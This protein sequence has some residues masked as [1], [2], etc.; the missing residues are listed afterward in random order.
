V[1]LK[2]V[3]VQPAQ[4]RNLTWLFALLLVLG[5]IFVGGGV[6]LSFFS[7]GRGVGEETKENPASEQPISVAA[8][9]GS[10]ATE[11]MQ[12]LNQPEIEELTPTQ[13]KATTTV[14]LPTT[15]PVPTD[16][17]GPTS[18]KEPTA[19]SQPTIEPSVA[20][21]PISLD[22]NQMDGAE[23]V[24]VPAG[25]FLMGSDADTDPYFYGAEGP[26]HTV[27][28]DEYW[29]YR[30]EVTN[31]MYQKC[32]D[33]QACPRPAK[34]SS[35]TRDDYFTNPDYANYPVVFV[36]WRHAAA[37]CV[38]AGG[39]L[40]YEAEW[41]KAARGTDGRLFPWGNSPPDDQLV[42][43]N[44]NDTIAVGNYPAGASPYGV[45]DM[46]GNVIEWVFDFF[47]P[48]YYSIS[49][50]I[51]PLGPA[52]GSARVFRG[53][54]YHNPADGIRTV[55]RGSRPESHANVDFGFRCV[56]EEP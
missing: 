16:P 54:S 47:N 10:Q 53:G 36:S 44:T 17:P 13:V 6:Y 23:L 32:M 26:S 1:N 30:T 20:N 8:E 41:E 55:M 11:T 19:T 43:F 49:P 22:T 37:Y 51:N 18:T 45:Y 38:W 39:R 46:A 7:N 25:E 34:N 28:L 56:V 33:V 35:N 31:A 12:I 48:N 29:I 52:N 14:F 24:L 42:R 5:L 3:P 40:P 21:Q 15:T 4:R 50:D 9:R 27:S 2:G